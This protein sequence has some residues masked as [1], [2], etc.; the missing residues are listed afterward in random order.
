MKFETSV[1]NPFDEVPGDTEVVQVNNF[2]KV[3]IFPYLSKCFSDFSTEVL[4]FGA[5]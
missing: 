3:P 4:P 5:Q 1:S 2:Q